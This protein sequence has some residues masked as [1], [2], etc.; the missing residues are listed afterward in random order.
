MDQYTALDGATQDGLNQMLADWAWYFTSLNKLIGAGTGTGT[1]G[2]IPDPVPGPTN[3][4]GDIPDTVKNVGQAGQVTG[5]LTPF[6][7][8]RPA[9]LDTV[10]V[11]RLP[12]VSP[13]SGHSR[14]DIAVTVDGNGLNP[15]IQRQL[16]RTL[17]E[18][19]RNSP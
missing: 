17:T 14:K 8:S 2:D 9:A 16:V 11:S 18:I 6:G 19:E 5:M 13:S 4:T 12:L 7:I 1:V 3:K 15:Y 10:P